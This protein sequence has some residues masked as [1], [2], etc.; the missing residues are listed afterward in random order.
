MTTSDE[1]RNN[2]CGY[3]FEISILEMPENQHKRNTPSMPYSMGVSGRT[4]TDA[5]LP[6]QV[7]FTTVRPGDVKKKNA[8]LNFQEV[9]FDGKTIRVHT[10]PTK[11]VSRSS[12]GQRK[13]PE[14]G[15]TLARKKMSP[16]SNIV[17][18]RF[19]PHVRWPK[20]VSV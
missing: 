11:T 19:M 9:T 7:G 15:T 18:T 2:K 4:S 1:K 5:P 20:S 8:N 16:H 14:R 13:L 17:K 6:F 12:D 10:P 3:Y